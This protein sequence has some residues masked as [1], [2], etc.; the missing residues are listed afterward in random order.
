[1]KPSAVFLAVMT[2][3]LSVAAQTDDSYQR[4]AGL[5]KI[6]AKL[7]ST[8]PPT[9]VDLCLGADTDARLAQVNKQMMHDM[10]S[11][12]EVHKSGNTI[13]TDS[14]CKIG[15]RQSTS[16]QVMTPDGDNGYS[17][18]TT[19]HYDRPLPSHVSDVVTSETAKW[20]GA[21]PADMKPGDEILH[22]S[23]TAP[24]GTK[25]NILQSLQGG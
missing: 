5:W 4:K 16:H 8:Q 11:K 3:S 22:I 20:S 1:M 12:S 6:S 14:V 21:C 7:D 15:S 18:V 2:L 17:S 25:T 19:I 9:A 10:C 13:V 24:G 23:P